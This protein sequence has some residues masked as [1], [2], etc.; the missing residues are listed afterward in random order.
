MRFSL[1]FVGIVGI[2]VAGCGSDDGSS[3]TL[4]PAAYSEELARAF[5]GRTDNCC[6]WEALGSPTIQSYNDCMTAFVPLLSQNVAAIE[7]SVEAGRITWDATLASACTE[8]LG[9]VACTESLSSVL[10]RCAEVLQPL[11]VD[12]DPCTI[13]FE[14]RNG[15]CAFDGV[16]DEAGTCANTLPGDPCVLSCV[17]T[18]TPRSCRQ[19]CT[20]EQLCRTSLGG[21]PSLSICEERSFAVATEPC[22]TQECAQGLFCNDTLTC[23][24][25][26]DNGRACASNGQCASTLCQDGVCATPDACSS[27]F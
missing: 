24:P 8:D 26:L 15:V 6:E 3:N 23:E 12:G 22:D 9:A 27:L 11:V 21:D 16:D 7:S 14:C 18:T 5:C 25:L 19:T 10:G 2:T 20:G 1:Y 4:L 13:D 17:G